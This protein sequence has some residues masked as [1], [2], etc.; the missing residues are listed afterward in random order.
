MVNEL[1]IFI[2]TG[3]FV[4]ARNRSDINHER[5]VELLRKALKGEYR[6]TLTLQTTYL[7]KQ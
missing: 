6:G 4:A 5:T 2:D 7:T 1:S 3:V